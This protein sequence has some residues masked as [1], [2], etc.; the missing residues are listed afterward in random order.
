MT[1]RDRAALAYHI[2]SC[3]T[4]APT[5]SPR[6]ESWGTKARSRAEA[7]GIGFVSWCRRNGRDV[8]AAALA[9]AIQLNAR[10][11]R[12]TAVSVA[13]ALLAG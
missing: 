4:H 2:A 13:A 8:D 6:P 5:P 11:G 1:A 9:D 7:F 12:V 3:S 10:V